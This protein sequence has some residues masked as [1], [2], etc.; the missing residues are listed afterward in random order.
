[1]SDD[2]LIELVDQVFGASLRP[3]H[4]TDFEHC[5]ECAEHDD[6][7]R[8]RDRVSLTIDDVGNPGWDPLVA[9]SASG[10]AYFMPTLV[11]LAM[12]SDDA[13]DGL[14]F[15]GHLMMHFWHGGRHNKCLI[16]FDVAQR[17]AI[18]ALAEFLINERSHECGPYLEDILQ[19]HDYWSA[20]PL[21]SSVRS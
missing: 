6:L 2:Q 7:L 20:G 18:V 15:A 16:D 9:S 4:F 3:E 21:A 10:I 8:S 12:Q 1:M 14:W 13:T 11:R 17:D 19:V 5:E